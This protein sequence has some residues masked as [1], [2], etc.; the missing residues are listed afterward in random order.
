MITRREGFE[1]AVATALSYS[2]ILGANDRVQLGLIGAGGRGTYDMTV[3]QKVGPVDVRAVCDVYGQRIDQA[4]TKAPG[5]K[6]YYDHLRL[7]EMKEIDAV[8]I[9]TPDHW[10]KQTAIDALNAGKDVYVEKPLT[11]LRSE[12]PEVVRA[13]RVN[14]RIC[15]VGMQQRSGKVYLEACER[16]FKSGAIGKVTY[17]HCVWN[18]GPARRLRMQPAEKPSNLDWV[19][20]LGPVKYRDWNPAQYMNFRAFLDFGGGKM[21]DFGAHWI[22]VVHMFLGVDA[23]RAV[24]AA[25]GV[26]YDFQ[27]GRTAP[28]TVSAV[29]DYPGFSVYFESLA[30]GTPDEYH[31]EFLGDRGRLYINRNRY[32]FHS[33]E[34]GVEPIVQRFPGDITEEHVANFL[35]CCRT[36]KLPNADVYIGHRSCQATLLAVESYVEKRRIVFDGQREEVLPLSA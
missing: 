11:R 25:G 22:D 10:H 3:F 4:L 24:T 15:Q 6:P 16:F 23:P 27:D 13:A 32:E 7:L 21:T 19:R 30:V 14:N 26:Y 1:A 12:G 18:S 2:R 28:D 34:K 33:A 20:Y 31:V 36:R 8:L 5:A 29:F 17:V 35:E 9:G